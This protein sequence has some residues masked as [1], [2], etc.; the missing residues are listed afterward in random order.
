[1]PGGMIRPTRER[2]YSTL[3]ASVKAIMAEADS[4]GGNLAGLNWQT[5][6]VAA[7]PNIRQLFEK[8]YGT[9]SVGAA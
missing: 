7:V 1:M 8:T 9:Q 5:A 4:N 3:R 2:G 6:P